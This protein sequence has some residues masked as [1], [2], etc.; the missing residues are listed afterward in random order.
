MPSAAIGLLILVRS[1]LGRVVAILGLDRAHRR[2]RLH[3]DQRPGGPGLRQPDVPAH[4]GR[5]DAD[6]GR[7]RGVV[8]PIAWTDDEMR[9]AVFAPAALGA[10]VFFGAARASAGSTRSSSWADRHDA[11]AAGARARARL[12]GRRSALSAGRPLGLRAAGAAARAR[13]PG[14]PPRAAGA[15]A[16]GLAPAGLAAGPA[17]R[18]D[19]GLPR[20]PA[21][22][23]STWSRTS[24]GRSIENHQIVD[25]LARRPHRPD[26]ARP[27][28]AMYRYHNTLTDAAPGVVAVVG[29]AARPQARL[30]LPGGPGRR[31]VGG[32]LR[33]RQPRH[34]V[35]GASRRWSSSRHGLPPAEPGAGAHRDRVR[36]PVDPVGAHRP[37]RLPVP[38]LHG[39]AV[40]RAGPR[41]LLAELWH[42]A[43]RRTWLLA[44]SPGPSAI[45]GPAPVAVLTA[46]VRVRRRRVGQPGLTGLPGGHPR[47]RADPAHGRRSPSSPASGCSS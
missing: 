27:D 21:R 1:A 43:S 7:G 23:A 13:R 32:D 2:P 6:R 28:G 4:H 24:R 36:G 8:H 14:P 16:R 3:G 41:L 47:L 35:A 46:A 42:G 20:R 5:A 33:R 22:S 29:L 37:G 18:L 17:G 44:R 9:F 34:L 31:D 39:A 12:A 45:V 15:A 11:A 19:G 38:L 26:A 10:L 30:V 40:R 25:R